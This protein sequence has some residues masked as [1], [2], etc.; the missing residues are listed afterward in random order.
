[1]FSKSQ[2]LLLSKVVEKDEKEESTNNFKN[3]KPKNKKK[4]RELSCSSGS[5]RM[6]NSEDEGEAVIF[7]MK[8]GI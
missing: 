5:E 8:K 6:V 3:K 7:Q 4:K 1:M 2:E